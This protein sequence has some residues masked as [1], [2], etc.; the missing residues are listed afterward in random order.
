M[1]VESGIWGFGRVQWTG[2]SRSSTELASTT[3]KLI[4]Q[5]VVL[6]VLIFKW[7]VCYSITIHSCKVLKEQHEVSVDTIK[8][9]SCL[10][11]PTKIKIKRRV[12][13]ENFRGKEEYLIEY[14]AQCIMEEKQQS[15]NWRH[16]FHILTLSTTKKPE[17]HIDK[18]IN[19]LKNQNFKHTDLKLALTGL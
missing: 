16:L 7:S 11:N 5:R 8:C 10:P 6:Q 2:C 3:R 15:G 12:S 14:R 1:G 17:N 9:L 19:M 18:R 13:S 4:S